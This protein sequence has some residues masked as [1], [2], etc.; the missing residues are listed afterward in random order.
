MYVF[1]V[2]RNPEYIYMWVCVRV[3][4]VWWCEVNLWIS[5]YRTDTTPHIKPGWKKNRI[6]IGLKSR[7]F[8]NSFVSLWTSDWL[9]IPI[10]NK[11]LT[12]MTPKTRDSDYT[13]IWNL[14]TLFQS[15]KVHISKLTAV[16]G[17]TIL[18]GS[19]SNNTRLSSHSAEIHTPTHTHM[20]THTSHNKC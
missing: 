14:N 4:F 16:Q 5:G 19:Q 6:M 2:E 1:L 11:W 9:L 12:I 17:L 13:N 8:I 20:H 10:W 15:W 7:L 18:Y 3:G